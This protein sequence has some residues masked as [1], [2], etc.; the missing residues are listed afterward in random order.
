M[1]FEV[2]RIRDRLDDAERTLARSE[3]MASLGDLA[4]RKEHGIV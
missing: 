2:E 1:D 3:K 4:E